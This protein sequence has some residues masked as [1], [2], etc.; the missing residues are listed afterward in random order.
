MQCLCLHGTL[1]VFVLNVGTNTR[2][3]RCC[4]PEDHNMSW[5]SL[6][7]NKKFGFFYSR[8]SDKKTTELGVKIVC[9]RVEVG[10]EEVCVGSVGLKLAKA[11]RLWGSMGCSLVPRGEQI[12]SLVPRGSWRGSQ[13]K[14]H[15]EV[16]GDGNRGVVK[17]GVSV[18]GKV[19]GRWLSKIYRK[20]WVMGD[21]PK[22]KEMGWSELKKRVIHW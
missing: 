15:Q 8:T 19:T 12:F 2:T 21:P 14:L 6:I 13:A 9:G 5:S 10:E 16:W 4:A 22:L 17:K 7:A 11:A 1:N 18:G 3:K 20:L